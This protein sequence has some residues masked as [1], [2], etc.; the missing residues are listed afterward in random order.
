MPH[1]IATART[2]R[3][4]RGARRSANAD[5]GAGEPATLASRAYRALRHDIISARLEPG[6]KLHIGRLCER[7]GIGLAP[8]R[9]ALNRLS[10]HS[11]VVQ[12]DQRG[13]RVAPATR[14]ALEELVRTRCWLNAIGLRESI[15]HGD[16]GWADAVRAAYRRL[17]EHDSGARGSE[18]PDGWEDAHRHFH[19]TLVSACGSQW[20]RG[21]CAELFDAAERYR[22]LSRLRRPRARGRDEHGAIA[23]AA[24]ARDA[25][26]AVALLEAH[27]RR[28]AFG[29]GANGP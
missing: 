18:R 7:Y 15:A 21:Y 17:R 23:R 3:A 9:E 11:L 26:R 5:P 24:V 29:A 28:T 25:E 2:A 4:G 19:D 20:L 1:P 8:M 22:H 14:E 12:A 6:S 16:A 10:R 13:F 27:L